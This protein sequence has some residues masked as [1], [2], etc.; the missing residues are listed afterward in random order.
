MP[1]D[2]LVKQH[3]A[4]VQVLYL[5][6]KHLKV[7][8]CTEG[9]YVVEVRP[10]SKPVEGRD[11]APVRH[12]ARKTQDVCCTRPLNNEYMGSRFHKWNSYHRGVLARN[13]FVRMSEGSV[14]LY[15]VSWTMPRCHDRRRVSFLPRL[16]IRRDPSENLDLLEPIFRSERL[17]NEW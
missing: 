16:V 14:E 4:C 17:G 1:G 3:L 5:G 2:S 7:P 13:L 6:R 9:G 11:G 15:N 12:L 8:E 10:A